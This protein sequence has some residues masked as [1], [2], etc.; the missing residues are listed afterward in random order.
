LVI[1]ECSLQLR[2]MRNW[3]VKWTE[4]PEFLDFWTLE[5]ELT[6][7]PETSVW[8]DHYTLRDNPEERRSSS[9]SYYYYY[10]Y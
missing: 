8:N 10:Y 4:G 6:S 1:M 9:S 2:R 3:Y 5:T 7:C